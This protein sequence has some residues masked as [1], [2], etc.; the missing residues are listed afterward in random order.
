MQNYQNKIAENNKLMHNL[1]NNGQAP[2]QQ[3]SSLQNQ[4]MMKHSE[5]SLEAIPVVK[6]GANYSTVVP[7]QMA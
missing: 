3:M 5:E 7:N 1:N 2:A 4:Y 6:N